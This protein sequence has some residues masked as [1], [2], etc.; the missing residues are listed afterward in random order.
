[1]YHTTEVIKTSIRQGQK[2]GQAAWVFHACDWSSE[3]VVRLSWQVVK[4]SVNKRK[5]LQSKYHFLLT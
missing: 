4:R 1:M 3:K 2:G 5:V